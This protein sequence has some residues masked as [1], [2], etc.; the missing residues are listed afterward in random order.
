MELRVRFNPTKEN[1]REDVFSPAV[2]RARLE[3][4]IPVTECVACSN[5]CFVFYCE[6]Y[7]KNGDF[8][9]LIN[10]KLTFG[11]PREGFIDFRKSRLGESTALSSL[12]LC[13]YPPEVRTV[14]ATRYRSA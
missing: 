10:Q 1:R 12:C 9:C 8:R 7:L 2:F 4:N 5:F 13:Q 14:H 11:L 6:I 3:Q